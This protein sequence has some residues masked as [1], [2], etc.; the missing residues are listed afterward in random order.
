MAANDVM[1][2]L[3]VC[4]PHATWLFSFAVVPFYFFYPL[5][6]SNFIRV[7]LSDSVARREE[8]DAILKIYS[9]Q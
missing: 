3:Y 7:Y 2:C 5:L 1:K 9:K 6:V 4:A 8:I